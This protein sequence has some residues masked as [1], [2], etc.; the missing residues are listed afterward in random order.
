MGP[1]ASGEKRRYA[2][3]GLPVEWSS[4]TKR[5]DR[6]RQLLSDRASRWNRRDLYFNVVST[7][8]DNQIASR[9]IPDF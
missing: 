4:D 8:M 7:R 9:N 6:S 2:L 5:R 1:H 3:S